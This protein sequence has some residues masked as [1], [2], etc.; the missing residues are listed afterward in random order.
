LNGFFAAAVGT[1]T[2]RYEKR[3]FAAIGEKLIFVAENLKRGFL[4]EARDGPDAKKY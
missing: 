1:Y 2:H 4:L 3:K